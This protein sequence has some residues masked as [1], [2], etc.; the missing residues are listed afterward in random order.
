MKRL[1]LLFVILITCSFVQAQGRIYDIAFDSVQYQY[2]R[3]FKAKQLIKAGVGL[4]LFQQSSVSPTW[5]TFAL[6]IT[7]EHKINKAVSII[8]GLETQYNF[9]QYAQLYNLN[10]PLGLRYYFSLGKRMKKRDDSH[11]FFS[12]YIAVQTNN[13]LF[14]S[15]YYDTPNP[16]VERYYR[17]QFLD[18]V[19]YWKI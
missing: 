18:H 8:G 13:S 3:S 6:D 1:L 16:A 11:S 5:K 15:L 7:A 17:G 4:P 10:M 9:S 2:G 12:Y 19:C 14:S